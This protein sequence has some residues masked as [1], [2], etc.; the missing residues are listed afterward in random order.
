MSPVVSQQTCHRR[1]FLNC[2]HRTGLDLSR[3]QLLPNRNNL[4]YPTRSRLARM[5]TAASTGGAVP[6]EQSIAVSSSV[7]AAQI[8]GGGWEHGKTGVGRKGG[9]RQR[10]A[11]LKEHLLAKL[12][13]EL[14]VRLAPVVCLNLAYF[15]DNP[16]RLCP[17]GSPIRI[18]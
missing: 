8:V 6:R 1:T 17:A 16:D 7:L 4:S 14:K 15:A 3:A 10:T 9:R 2:F 18:S 13:A 5:G 11:F 12:Q